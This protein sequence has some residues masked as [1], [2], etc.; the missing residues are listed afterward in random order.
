M[1]IV[2]DTKWTSMRRL[3]FFLLVIGAQLSFSQTPQGFLTHR[4]KKGETFEEILKQYEITEEQL[5]EYNPLLGEIGIKKRMS[6]RIP[7]YS[8][9]SP[10][11]ET[12]VEVSKP[13]YN[14]TIHTV[15]PK[16]TK[17]RLAYEYGMTLAELDSLNPQIKDGLKIGQEIQIRNKEYREVLPEKDSLYNYYKVLPAEG[18]YRIEKKLGV[19]RAVLDSLNPSLT[20]T[21]LQQGMILRIPDALSGQ[22][23]IENDLLVERV[24]LKD[25]LFKKKSIK[26]GLLL[27]FRANE[28][29]FDSIEDTKRTLEERNLHTISLDFYS[30]V[31]HALEQVAALG[32]KVELETFDTENNFSRL[33]EIVDSK[34]LEDKDLLV[35]P[36]IPANFDFISNQ[37]SLSELPKIAPL[38]TRPVAFRKNVFQSVTDEKRFREHMYTFLEQQLDTTQNVVIVADAENRMIE[39]ELQSRF[40]WSIRIR[41]E[42]SDYL[43]PE[44]VDSLLI[45]SIPNKIIL[46]TQS[47]PLIA[48]ALSQFGAQNTSER[49]V[50]VFTTFRSNAYDNENLSRKALGGIRFTYPSGFKPLEQP[51]ERDFVKKFVQNYG[52]PPNKEA[53]RAHDVVL[54]VILRIA[55]AQD[56]KSSLD[57]GETQYQSN[58]FLYSKNQNESYSNDSIYILEHSGYEILERKE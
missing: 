4:V 29:V 41:P 26:I 34:A 5:F 3:L 13:I 7:V 17:W 14:Y 37:A 46:E 19:S 11:E 55:V 27:P 6:L 48:S 8:S 25:S 39:R 54:D 44:L 1:G 36:L 49:E 30:G 32:I 22:L 2:F 16:E 21:G 28:I 58:R 24:N 57:L 33:K 35:G 56:L 12:T 40:P 42:A 43:L 18:Y 53:I 52:K 10:L 38:S 50:Q 51:L 23:K 20:E 9:P 15:Q 47:F 45:D 31:L